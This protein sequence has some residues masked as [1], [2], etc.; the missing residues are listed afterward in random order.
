MMIGLALVAALVAAAAATPTPAST[1]EY[2]PSPATTEWLYAHNWGGETL[3]ADASNA[4]FTAAN[5]TLERRQNGQG[6]VFITE[7]INWGGANLHVLIPLDIC[8]GV[9]G[10]QNRISSF[11][12][13]A[14]FRCFGYQSNACTPTTPAFGPVVSPGVSTLAELDQGGINWNDKINGFICSNV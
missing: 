13:D 9:V 6:G 14:G 12:P 8:V 10:W 3:V 11:G 2:A 5:A 1:A 7:D 4:I